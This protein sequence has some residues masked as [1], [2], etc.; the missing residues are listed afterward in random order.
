MYKHVGKGVRCV[1]SNVC[2]H[3]STLLWQSFLGYWFVPLRIKA[4][5]PT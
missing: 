1:W 2:A 4:F 3:V 5:L